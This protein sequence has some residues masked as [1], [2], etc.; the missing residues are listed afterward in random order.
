MV[1]F[2]LPVL[3]FSSNVCNRGSQKFDGFSGNFGCCWKDLTTKNCRFLCQT[4]GSQGQV[5]IGRVNKLF[6]SGNQAKEGC[7]IMFIVRSLNMFKSFPSFCEAPKQKL[8]RHYFDRFD[9][10]KNVETR[11]NQPL[12][13]ARDSCPQSLP[14]VS[15]SCHLSAP[16]S[17]G[18]R[19]RRYLPPQSVAGKHPVIGP[20]QMVDG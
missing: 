14:S 3:F 15:V 6:E 18:L 1:G 13:K 11:P 2:Q 9:C 7:P 4:L 10:G 20:R 19:D 12:Q 17:A 8:E 5:G 16:L